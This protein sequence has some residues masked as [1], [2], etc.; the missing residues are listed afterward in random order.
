MFAADPTGGPVWTALERRPLASRRGI[1]RKA[2]EVRPA[3]DRYE[4]EADRVADRV[5]GAPSPSAEGAL[6]DEASRPVPVVGAISSVVQRDAEDPPGRS[7][8]QPGDSLARDLHASS[9]GGSPLDAEAKSFMEP[10]FGRDLSHVRVHTDGKA[11]EMAGQL[12][13]RAFTHGSDIFIGRGQPSSATQEGRRLLAHE[14]THVIQQGGHSSVQ[15]KPIIQR[16]PEP[17]A[18]ASAAT[19]G[20]AAAK[21][22]ATTPAAEHAPPAPAVEDAGVKR[23]GKAFLESYDKAVHRLTR[24]GSMAEVS[25]GLA[26]LAPEAAGVGDPRCQRLL[27]VAERVVAAVFA[28]EPIS[29]EAALTS[30][31][32][33]QLRAYAMKMKIRE[34]YFEARAETIDARR[35]RRAAKDKLWVTRKKADVKVKRAERKEKELD[36]A[37]HEAHHNLLSLLGAGAEDWAILT[38][39]V[40]RLGH[41]AMSEHPE[42]AALTAELKSAF[43]AEVSNQLY[44]ITEAHAAKHVIAEYKRVSGLDPF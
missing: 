19:E 28:T 14:L 1:Q 36:K 25:A 32:A 27:T 33:E 43:G 4:Q 37:S 41:A 9:G 26:K 23:R 35:K 30:R 31:E 10:R 6:E 2:L 12:Q 39:F 15:R 8:P 16:D 20:P 42:A 40:D 44:H 22:A 17:G 18:M 34:D 13:A 11:S 29:L 24:A 3:G 38:Q 5:V 7:Q 21:E